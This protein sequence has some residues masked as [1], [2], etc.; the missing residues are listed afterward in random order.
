MILVP[1]LIICIVLSL[2]A[3]GCAP[4]TQNNDK[5]ALS[6]VQETITTLSGLKST[7]ST[8]SKRRKR[9]AEL[10]SSTSTINLTCRD[11]LLTEPRQRV[12]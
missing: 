11:I 7:E 2:A 8:Q 12:A 4:K 9:K 5:D 6:D 10:P 1:D 3:G